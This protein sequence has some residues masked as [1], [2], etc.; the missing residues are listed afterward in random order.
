MPEGSREGG[1][2]G[3]GGAAHLSAGQHVVG[4][5]QDGVLVLLA[6]EGDGLH[7]LVALL[8]RRQLGH[9]RPHHGGLQLQRGRRALQQPRRVE[10]A[11]AAFRVSLKF[12]TMGDKIRAAKKL[13]SV[14]RQ[15]W[16]AALLLDAKAPRAVRMPS[17]HYWAQFAVALSQGRTK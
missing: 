2:E 6:Q 10:L 17:Q 8:L 12:G 16:H 3:R 9:L 5:A 1:G 13:Q 4:A 7:Q 15:A 11:A 14:A